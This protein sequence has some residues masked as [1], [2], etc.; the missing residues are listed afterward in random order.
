MTV[1]RVR[2]ERWRGSARL[3]GTTAFRITALVV[4]AFVATA[5]IV[6]GVL[7]WQ[8]NNLLSAQVL[9]GLS[10]ER[11]RLEDV[12]RT[13]GPAVLADAVAVR[14]KAPAAGG[15]LLLLLDPTGAKLAGNL[16]R[17][18]GELAG[19]PQGGTFSY[20]AGR[21]AVGIPVSLP[22]GA[23]LLVARD[24]SDQSLLID[25]IR[26]LFLTGF[27]LLSLTGLAGGLIASRLMLARVTEITDTGSTIMAGDLSRRIPLS[28]TGDE[29]DHLAENLNAM[30]ER[31]EQLMNAM[32]E[33]SDNIAHDLK[34]PLSRLR[35]RAEA[36]LR[37]PAGG[38][39]HADGLA[40]VIEDADAIIQTFNALLLI[41]RLEAG[42][43]DKSAETFDLSGLMHDVAELYEPVAEE[44]GQHLNLVAGVPVSINANRQL[45]G[46]AIANLIDNAI[47]YGVPAAGGSGEITVSLASSAS[48]IRVTVADRGT[49]IPAVDRQRVAKR[50][51]RLD[52]SRTKPGSGLGLSLVSAVARL[53]GGQMLLE[54]NAPGLRVVLVLPAQLLRRTGGAS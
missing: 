44:A 2:P 18:P 31:I 29:F 7:F 23:R 27:G 34:T 33:V 22:G 41:A 46:Q 9:R 39:A 52:Q 14:S 30:L 48:G 38:T 26:R 17:W 19:K 20:G 43:V 5:A 28:G 15:P 42:A 53:H 12:A 4:A 13:A 24:L 35:S 49:G 6:T 16:D 50:F 21:P 37:A 40:R 45:I 10:Q 25:R 11:A 8:T 36:V 32:R 47:K 1:G 3:F 51:V 54:D